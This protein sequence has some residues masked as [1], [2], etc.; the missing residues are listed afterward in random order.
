[1]NRKVLGDQLYTLREHCRTIPEI[2]AMLSYAELDCPQ[3]VFTIRDH[4]AF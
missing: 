1:M 3:H 4:P 2:A